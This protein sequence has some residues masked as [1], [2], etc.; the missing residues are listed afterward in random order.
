MANKKSAI[1]GSWHSPITADKVARSA[2]GLSQLKAD[3]QTLYWVEQF[4]EQ[5]GRRVIMR[6][7]RHGEFC[8]I[9]SRDY[10][11]RSRVHEYG[12]GDYAV[13]ANVLFFVNDSDQRVY[14]QDKNHAVTVLTP[15]PDSPMASRYADLSVT[16]DGSYVICVRETH[17]A[18]KEVI[19]EIVAIATDGSLTVTVLLSGNDF[20]ASPQ[21]SADGKH[22]LF[23][24]W[25]H[26]QMPWDG[27]WLKLAVLDKKLVASN[28]ITIAGG[29]NESVCQPC[30]GPGGAI[31]FVSDKANWWNLYRYHEQEVCRV[32]MVDAELGYPAW[33]FA[34]RCYTVFKDGRIFCL[35]N[36]KGR[37]SMVMV[38]GEEVETI[39]SDHDAFQPYVASI[40]R[41]VFCIGAHAASA[42]A[43]LAVDTQE[44]TVEMLHS[45][46]TLL[47]DSNYFSLP[48]SIE[49]P[50]DAGKT[51]YAYFYPP[52]N[53]V[54]SSEPNELPP[55]IVTC[56]GGPTAAASTALNLKIQYWTSRGFA[57][58]DVNYGGSTGYGRSYRERLQEQWGVVDVADCVN[59]AKYLVDQQRV[60]ASRLLIRGGSA[61]GLTVLAAL[62]F[63][64]I[65][66]AGA[67]YYGVADMEALMQ[68][69][70]KF[71]ARYGDKLVGAY[72]EKQAIYRERSPLYHTERLSTPIIFLQGME[73]KVVPPS[74]AEAMIAA[75]EKKR[76]PY[77]YVTFPHEQHGFRDSKAIQR[78]L[79]CE[80]SFY[81]QILGF[82][83]HDALAPVAI[84]H[85]S[86][87][88]ITS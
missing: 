62:T 20:Y 8:E 86:L 33:I 60:D 54:Y 21:V 44:H 77:A 55:L 69:T 4:P 47:L 16:P 66:S 88:T 36:E 2:R 17:L 23:L 3:G 83:P 40:G 48:E 13:Q 75:L 67:S 79:E 57:V 85:L 63:Y 5:K 49:F 6:R 27:T 50:T 84:K 43:I 87:L 10:S 38:D 37:Y 73:D 30:F 45:S 25:N 72:P 15:I 68:D 11:V 28:I 32:F 12:G 7:N 35:L 71:E 80:L 53:P 39:A 1:C 52:K 76:L 42:D 34:T 51:A 22:L 59:A 61:G 24:T 81:A 31:Y 78:A 82:T 70:H 74:Q 58:V 9:T 29:S 64:D 41:K 26:P 56:H 46:S 19:N 14:R 65:F 18:T